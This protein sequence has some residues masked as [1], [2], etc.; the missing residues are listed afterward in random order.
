NFGL[1]RPRVPQLG[2]VAGVLEPMDRLP[3]LPDRPPL[4]RE[5]RRLDDRLVAVV[6]RVKAVAAVDL[7][8]A[9]AGAEDRDAPVAL[10]RE[11][12]EA[13][14]EAVES[15]ARTDRVAG[16]DGDAADDLVREEGGAVGGEEVRL[17]GPEHEGRERI[18][19]PRRDE[20]VREPPLLRLVA[21]PVA[22]RR[23]RTRDD[24]AGA[25][26]AEREHR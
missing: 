23:D 25:G 26:G 9:L 12:D 7:E 21:Q 15:V 8:A 13:G 22:P 10:V 16:D 18:R 3:H 20:V 1:D 19:A 5:R 24:P 2:A 6:E 14:D 11:C 4:E 17:V